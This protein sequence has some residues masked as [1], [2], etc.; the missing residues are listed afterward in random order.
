MKKLLKLNIIA[1]LNVILGFILAIGPFGIF[2]VCQR[3]MKNGKHM[4]CFYSG[5]FLVG[6]AIIIIAVNLISIKFRKKIVAIIMH[7]LTLI[8][9]TLCYMVPHR[10][11]PIGDKKVNGWEFGLCKDPFC[12]NT[13]NEM[14]CLTKTMPAVHIIIA[15]LIFLSI[16]GLIQQFL[17]REV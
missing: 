13:G 16:I 5:I 2:P 11:I 1:V 9:A 15:V 7:L 6:M 3:L 17:T 8:F 4:M 14:T 12:L 10:M